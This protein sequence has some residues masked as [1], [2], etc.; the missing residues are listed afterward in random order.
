MHL[1]G[2]SGGV[3]AGN[4]DGAACLLHDGRI[5]AAVEEERLLGIKHANG[6]LPKKAIEYCLA[7]AGIGIRDVAAVG[8]PGITYRNFETILRDY[9][10]LHFGHAP[11][12]R[13]FDHHHCHAASTYYYSA[14]QDAL[15][16]T[17]DFSGD[18]TCT[19]LFHAAGSEISQVLRI[20]KPN[21][22]G[23]FYSMLTQYL[24]FGKDDEEYKVMG[25]ASYGEPRYD[26]S[27]VL[28]AEG[29]TYRLDPAFV[30]LAPDLPAPSKQEPLFVRL[31]LPGA[32]RVS[33]EKITQYHMDVAASAQVALEEAVLNVLRHAALGSPSRNLCLAGGVSL[34][35]VM[36]KRVRETGLF[37]AVFVPPHTSDA[38]L[39][40]GAAAF[41]SLEKQGVR[42]QPIDHCYWGPG[43]A[44]EEIETILRRC[45]VPF[46]RPDDVCAAAAA[47]LAEGRIV[48][49][50]QGGM[51]F[52]PR[53][54]GARSILADPRLP[55]MKD[56]VNFAVKFRE[57]FRPFA[58]SCL[59]ERAAE[60][61][62]DAVRSPYMTVTFD[63][64]EEKRSE[65]PAITHVD[66]TARVQTVGAQESPLYHRMIG[67]F[68]R[69]T[70]VPMVLNTSMNVQGQPIIANPRTALALFY[71]TGLA[72]MAIGPYYLRK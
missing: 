9:L 28:C 52:G 1:L 33:G 29:E 62:V 69:R 14:L 45:A 12:V 66:G 54:L 27:A 10:E 36:N 32:H 16:L 55:E 37:D 18:R 63:V 7:R 56:R 41:L 22:L 15:V 13:L 64:R 42:P 24:G 6:H 34:N 44:D 65:V 19:A 26:L 59:E 71:S 39:S 67:E 11:E 25:L 31:P 23:V 60:Y 40:L 57:G 43:F 61:F 17:V 68:A 47:D 49:W 2:I 51:E 72:G 58:P 53:A 50:F 38:G 21:S 30:R 3:L 20:E 46:E 35:C 48:G 5:V 4:Q 70:G 8:F